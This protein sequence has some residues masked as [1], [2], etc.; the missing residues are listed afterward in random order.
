[1][2]SLKNA[3]TDL[4]R[5]GKKKVKLVEEGGKTLASVLVR[6]N[7]LKGKTCRMGDCHICVHKGSKGNC[8]LRSTCYTNTCLICKQRGMDVKYWGET[9]ESTYERSKTHMDEAR[10]GYN[11]S[12]IRQHLDKFH[13]GEIVNLRESSVLRP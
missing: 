2:K 12:H 8:R 10:R 4:N 11:T 6:T 9:S 13:S 1:M 7:P 3:E 5:V